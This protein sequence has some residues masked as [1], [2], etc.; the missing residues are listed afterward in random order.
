MNAASGKPKISASAHPQNRRLLTGPLLTLVRPDIKHHGAD[1]AGK[2]GNQH[3]AEAAFEY[4]LRQKEA[5]V[6]QIDSAADHDAFAN[7]RQRLKHGVIPEQQLQQ[8]RKIA[9]RLDVAASNFR[10]QPIAR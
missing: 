8:E 5:A 9:D 10:Q 7:V 2:Q 1:N 4:R 6:V 3:R